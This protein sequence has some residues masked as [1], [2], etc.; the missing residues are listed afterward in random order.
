MSRTIVALDF[1]DKKTT[2]DFLS[3]FP[4]EIYVK[5]GMELFY[6]EGPQ[7]ITD[8]KNLGHKIFLDL[9]IWDIP[10]TA[11][12]AF[13]S[14]LDLNVDMINLHIF[15]GS[16]MM[17][18]AVN[19]T[20][21][22]LNPPLLIGVT[23]LTSISNE[24]LNN[25]LLIPYD[26]KQAAL[27]YAKL[28]YESGLNGVVCSAFEAKSIHDN[29]NSNFKTICPGIRL[30][31]DSKGYQKRVATPLFAKQQGADYIVVGRSI[32]KSDNPYK[33]YL[34]IKKEFEGE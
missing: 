24:I 31:S 1:K 3:Q 12:G 7:I 8:I 21:S 28:A 14:L 19:I 34:K 10:N 25:E 13:N 30:E 11:K 16:E 15:G 18:E 26:T 17:K 32:T 6:K 5:V 2:L 27:K 20:K 23:I 4:E 29:I 22:H 9:K 33:T